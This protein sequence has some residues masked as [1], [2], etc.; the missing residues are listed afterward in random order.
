MLPFSGYLP[1]QMRMTILFM[2]PEHRSKHR[3]SSV[4]AQPAALSRWVYR[5]LVVCLLA[6]PILG[7]G[8]AFAAQ[9][10]IVGSDLYTGIGLLVRTSVETGGGKLLTVSGSDGDSASLRGGNGTSIEI[11]ARL[12]L[13]PFERPAFETELTLGFKKAT[14]TS[15]S[16]A[17]DFS[18]MTVALSQ[19]YRFQSG[20]RLGA[21]VG[22][23]LA[24]TLDIDLP[25][26]ERTSESLA[27]A[28][29]YRLMLEY[30]FARWFAIGARIRGAT[31]T[32]DGESVDGNSA[33]IYLTIQSR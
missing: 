2:M 13:R 3:S 15:G 6:M 24:P 23:R 16:G 10:I 26:Y 19:F 12:D 14:M 8:N 1:R 32:S 5:G 25:G 11:G 28:P 22:L 30:G 18:H 33:G 7:T 4:A 21:G 9:R 29:E 17:A 27:K 31:W 20:V